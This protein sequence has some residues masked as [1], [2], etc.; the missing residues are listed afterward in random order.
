GSR[1]LTQ[2]SSR[3]GRSDTEQT[4]LAVIPAALP[5]ATVVTTVTPVAKC[6]IACRYATSS[7]GTALSRVP[8]RRP[9]NDAD[10]VGV[11][12]VR[13]RPAVQVVLGEALLREGLEAVELA[14]RLHGVDD[15]H[16]DGL[17]VA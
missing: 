16:A 14:H 11:H 10:V 13:H 17:V 3:T 4:A 5:S 9:A 6:A 7:S 1:L 15:V 8:V 2:T 12:Q